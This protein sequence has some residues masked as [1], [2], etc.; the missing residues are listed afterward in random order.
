MMD[1]LTME[2]TE[3][4]SNQRVLSD[5]LERMNCLELK[6]DAGTEA[7]VVFGVALSSADMKTGPKGSG[8]GLDAEISDNCAGSI[9]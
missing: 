2:A 6:G 3:G 5:G 1:H 9:I 8:T 4:A 7:S